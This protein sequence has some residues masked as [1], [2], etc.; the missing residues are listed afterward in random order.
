MRSDL[1]HSPPHKAG[2]SKHYRITKEELEW[3]GE[4]VEELGRVVHAVC[5]ERLTK[6]EGEVRKA[7]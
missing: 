2:Y 7:G 5:T 4:Q 6:L 3:L 1:D